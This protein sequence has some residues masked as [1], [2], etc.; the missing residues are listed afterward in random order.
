MNAIFAQGPISGSALFVFS[1]PSSPPTQVSDKT[2]PAIR[3]RRQIG[4]GARAIIVTKPARKTGR[5][6]SARSMVTPR[7]AMKRTK[8]FV[9]SFFALVVTSIAAVGIHAA[10][11]IPSTLMSPVDYSVAKKAIEAETR[12]A[13]SRCRTLAGADKD[14]CKAEVRAEE[15]VKKADLS[16]R[17]HGTVAAANDAREAR[18]KAHYDVAKARCSTRPGEER[19]DCLRTAREDKNRSLSN[20]RLAS[21]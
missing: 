16:A 7:K 8:L 14:I 12:N 10:V 21:T 19:I 13:F 2:V 6:V 4:A 5:R 3:R 17:Y 11:D 15:R 1:R 20:E 9:T 18:V